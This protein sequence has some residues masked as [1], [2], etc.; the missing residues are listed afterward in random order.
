[1]R[2]EVETRTVI[3]TAADP[4]ELELG[5]IM[6]AGRY[7]GASKRMLNGLSWTAPDYSIK[8]S[9]QK[10]VAMG[11]K[12]AEHVVS[13]D[14]TVTKFVRDG[15]IVVRLGLRRPPFRSA[16]NAGR[17]KARRLTRPGFLR[18]TFRRTEPK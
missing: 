10:L 11:M 2:Q 3:L 12:D 9:R 5:I 15:K 13:I 16:L 18:T 7:R 6:P 17:E 8:F 14:W 1:M 4:V